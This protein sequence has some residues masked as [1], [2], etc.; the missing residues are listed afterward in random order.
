MAYKQITPCIGGSSFNVDF[1][2]ISV[3]DGDVLNLAFTN[4][5]LD[6]CYTVDY[7]AGT[8]NETVVTTSLVYAD[9]ATCL[10]PTPTPT[11]TPTSTPVLTIQ[12]QDCSTGTK[13][14]FYNGS[15]PTNIGDTYNITGGVNFNGCATIITN[16]AEGLLYDATGVI[17]TMTTGCG[18]SICPV[19][20]EEISLF[21]TITSTPAQL[22]QCST[23]QVV[24]F[25]VDADTAFVGGVYLA[26]GH[27]YSFIEF[28]G[29]GG[30]FVDG[31]TYSRCIDCIPI[32]VT[33]TP[34]PSPT[35]TPTVS[36]TP[37]A[38][39]STYCF[40]TTDASL[41]G[42][43]GNY[44]YT[45]SYNGRSTFSGDGTSTGYIYYNNTSWCLSTSVGGSCLLQGA[46][47]CY[48]NC[49]DFSSNVFY[50]GPC[51]TPTP[52]PINCYNFDFNAYF[53]CDWEPIPT[54]T[55]SIP[56]DDVSFDIVSV[57]V[58]PT[59][60]PSQDCS[61]RA[62]SFSLSGYT[63]Q[64][65]PTPSNTP[66]VTITRTVDVAGAAN[67]VILD[68]T[69]SC[70]LAKVLID[71]STGDEFYVSD[72]L[73]LSG[74]P[75][76][77]G[78]ILLGEFSDNTRKCVIY[79]RDDSNISS[80]I[81]VDVVLELYNDC[82]FCNVVPTPTPTVTS[83]PTQTPTITASVTPTQTPTQ[84]S[85]S[86]NT[87]TPTTTTTLTATPGTTAASTPS[88]TSTPT[89]TPTPTFV[90]V[91]INWVNIEYGTNTPGQVWIDSDMYINNVI[92][93]G[94]QQSSGTVYVPANSVVTFNQNCQTTSG[95]IGVFTLSGK[96]V[97]T[98][99][100]FY[101]NEITE[102]ITIYTRIQGSSFTALAGNTYLLTAAGD[103]YVPPPPVYV[104]Q[105]CSNIQ[106]GKQTQVVQNTE[107]PSV[108][109]G[110]V[111][112]DSY[113]NC[114]TYI[115]PFNSNY[116]VPPEYYE[117]TNSG[118]YF[119]TPSTK[120]ATC[121]DCETPLVNCGLTIGQ[122]Y[123]G[124]K[125]AYFFQ[126]G[127]IPYVPGQCHGIIASLSDQGVAQWGCMY[128][129]LPGAQGKLIGMGKQN[130]IDILNGC[131]QAGTAAKLCDAYQVIDNGVIY[132]DWFL[133]SEDELTQLCINKVIIGNFQT[134][135]FPY[136]WVSNEYTTQTG[137]GQG[138]NVVGVI[139]F[140]QNNC[141]V[142]GSLGKNSPAKVRA[143]RYF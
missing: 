5:L 110:D 83:T 22:S 130:T 70:I 65:T 84:T 93:N 104:Y 49:P 20:E 1:G 71:C 129:N 79:D 31:P 77:I 82:A 122:L 69:F 103:L 64:P 9:C 80:N 126:P 81:N 94:G 24:Y 73:T 63:V 17:F 88:V 124:G 75:V 8:F 50:S 142:D 107:V 89:R 119:G 45:G 14:R 4:S 108:V 136:Y 52:T 85:T 120:Y 62:V 98:N 44:D 95:E 16:T 21:T 19:I 138:S 109:I 99:T 125:I 127:D 38:C 51:V 42:Y 118:N 59:P 78:T 47:P 131:N 139:N 76:T 18:D 41:S 140:S 111:F 56:S 26:S 57:G 33:P 72:S 115:G 55:P 113:G 60:S 101:S 25:N 37:A 2:V 116:I 133:P 3:N 87:P 112:K 128:T 54:P 36:L 86:T 27:C 58:T 92:Q 46:S 74:T 134:N 100:V 66:T 6:G 121:T 12:F 61:G 105:S 141:T 114:W 11:P 13:F 30:D 53:D 23:G 117:V 135:A 91:T 10:A 132:S 123:Q 67:Y 96:N 29:P 90:L 7:D 40:N 32:P 48:F 68:E 102:P 43:S 28:S 35:P 15:L 143:I 97:T 137:N 34:Y 39:S 106:P